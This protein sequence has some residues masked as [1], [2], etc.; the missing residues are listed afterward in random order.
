MATKG[1]YKRGSIYWI[2]FTDSSNKTKFESSHSHKKRDA[3]ALLAKRKA[4]VNEGKYIKLKNLRK[5]TFNSL[6]DQ[7]DSFAQNQRAYKSKKYI[8]KKL[9][10][11][12]SNISLVKFNTALVEQFQTDKRNNGYKSA[13]ANRYTATLKHMFTKAFEWEMINEDTL[14]KI[15]KVKQLEENNQRLRYLTPEECQMLINVCEDYLKPIVLTALHTGMRKN[16]ILKLKWC[17]VDLKTALL[18][19]RTRRA[20]KDAQYQLIRLYKKH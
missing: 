5:Y 1:I 18:T 20:V 16:E 14:K 17:Q 4:E 15:R 13:T 11:Q 2:R 19:C 8:I 3:E 10:D 9:K 12:Y 7:Y 6:A